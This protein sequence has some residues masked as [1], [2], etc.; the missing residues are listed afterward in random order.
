MAGGVQTKGAA[1]CPDDGSPPPQ[2]ATAISL[3]DHRSS[4]PY[5]AA[6]T[7]VAYRQPTRSS[8]ANAATTRPHPTQHGPAQCGRGKQ[9]MR[10]RLWL[11]WVGKEYRGVRNY[12]YQPVIVIAKDNAKQVHSFGPSSYSCSAS[13]LYYALKNSAFLLFFFFEGILG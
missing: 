2:L 5:N 8:T 4:R 1:H 7:E 10:I 12:H 3:T 13:T 6:S 9:V 11:T